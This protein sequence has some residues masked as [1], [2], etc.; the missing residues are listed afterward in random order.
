MAVVTGASAGIG[1]AIVE[2]LAK[3]GMIVVG[4][5]RRAERITELSDKL[6][7]ENPTLV[8][9]LHSFKCDL[10]SEADIRAVFDWVD[11]KFGRVD[12]LINNAGVFK[13][14]KLLDPENSAL[15]RETIDTNIL[16]VAFCT[17]QAFQLM[18]KRG[19]DDGHVMIINSVAGHCVPYGLIK[20][21]SLNIYPSTKY[22]VTAMTEILRQEF[23]LFKTKTKITVTKIYS[24]VNYSMIVFDC[25]CFFAEH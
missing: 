4:L 13:E 20:N 8:G 5:A 18:Q 22:A 25:R 23:Q 1:A 2:D 9:Q 19:I 14:G 24:M 10:T 12:V 11:T 17:R 7:R 15:I 3:A 21:G 16:G 6:K